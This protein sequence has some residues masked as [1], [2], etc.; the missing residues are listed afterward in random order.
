[1][2]SF[3]RQPF[4]LGHDTTLCAGNALTLTATTPEATY[5]W[6]DGSTDSTFL[7]TAT[8]TY[9]VHIFLPC[10]T[11][12][13][14]IQVTMAPSQQTFDLG[15]DTGICAGNTVLLDAT[16]LGATY[17]W[18]NGSTNSTFTASTS[19]T[20]WVQVTAASCGPADDTIHI[21][22]GS[23]SATINLGNDSSIC[24]GSTLVLDAS[25]TGATYLWQDGA[26]GATYTVSNSGMYW[27]HV[28]LSCDTLRDTIQVAVG[29]PPPA[30]DLGN[31]TGLCSGNVLLLD[32]TVPGGTYLWQNGATGP[33]LTV[34]SGGLYWVRVFL[35]C[36]TLTDSIR[37]HTHVPITD[38][39]LPDSLFLC[40][41]QSQTLTAHSPTNAYVWSGG[42]TTASITVGDT[43]TYHVTTVDSCGQTIS[44]SC[45][46]A[47]VAGPGPLSQTITVADCQQVKVAP[48]AFPANNYL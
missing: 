5:L 39:D 30:I 24:P 29:I 48:D 18:Q 42:Q 16:V 15:N 26:T 25:T 2:Q 19:G 43:G 23:S 17:L 34:S 36:D 10:D 3:F 37:V 8:G 46:V 45:V 9:W 13:D 1:M 22:V 7:A 28:A 12:R 20:Y 35:P 31:D 21:T 11:L 27:V 41:G 47:Y 40:P 4:H 38:L 33:T 14:T 44:D 32:A 6:Q